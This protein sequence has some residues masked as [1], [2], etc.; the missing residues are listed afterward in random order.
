MRPF[1][2]VRWLH[3]P[4]KMK[5]LFEYKN[6][7]IFLYVWIHLLLWFMNDLVF[8]SDFVLIY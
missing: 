2:T 4:E 3:I 1:D 6:Q 8:Y 5:I 7:T